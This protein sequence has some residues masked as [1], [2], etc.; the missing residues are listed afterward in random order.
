LFGRQV[1]ITWWKP[2]PSIRW[3]QEVPPKRRKSTIIHGVKMY[4]ACDQHPSGKP[5]YLH[6]VTPPYGATVT[7]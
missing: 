2:A 3:R 7:C 5:E 6:A 4:K 1:R